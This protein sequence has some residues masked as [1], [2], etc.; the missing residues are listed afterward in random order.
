[1]KQLLLKASLPVALMLAAG[2][3]GALAGTYTVDPASPIGQRLMQVKSVREYRG[4]LPWNMPGVELNNRLKA[5]SPRRV[6]GEKPLPA[7][8]FENLPS[9][10]FI[11]G[12]DGSVWFYTSEYTYLEGTTDNIQT[13]TF[14]VYNS[15][16]ELQGSIHDEVVL[17]EGETRAVMAELDPS[18]TTK[19]FNSDSK[20]EVMVTFAINTVD[21]TVKYFNKAYSL[22][23]QKADGKDVPLM[24]IP[25][26][27]VDAINAAADKWSEDFYLTFV[28]DVQPDE[29]EIDNYES[30]VDYLNAFYERITIY[31]KGGYNQGPSVLET[32]Q[33]PLTHVPYDTMN[34]VYFMSKL[35]QGRP[36]FVVSQYEK[37]FLVDPTGFADDLSATADNNLV[38][39]IYTMKTNYDKQITKVSTTSIPS[40]QISSP[41]GLAYTYYGIGSLAWDKDID[42]TVNGSAEAPAFIVT[43]GFSLASDPDNIA[44]SYIVYDNA[45]NVKSLIAE[46]TDGVLL[47]S[48]IAGQ[49]PQAMFVNIEGNQY[50]FSFIDLYSG[51]LQMSLDQAVDGQPL[52]AIGDRVA[53]ADGYKYAFMM[54]NGETDKDKNYYA[55]V[56]WINR[57]GT[58]DHIDRINVGQ[59]TLRVSVNMAKDVLNPYL[60]DT[61]AEMEY[62]VLTGRQLTGETR[63]N[64]EFH[65]VKANQNA[66]EPLISFTSEDGL[67][68]VLSF[69]FVPGSDCDRIHMAYNNNYSY[70]VAVYELPLR[71][72]AGGDGTEANP[73]LIASI[74]DL[75]QIKR[76]ASA[77]YKLSQDIDG[78]GFA[79][80]P[81]KD[82][83]GVLKGD[84]KTISNFTL[85][86][87]AYTAGIFDTATGTSEISGI[88][89]VD[90]V[91]RLNSDNSK[92]ALL[93]GS[94]MGATIKDIHVYGLKASGSEFSGNFGG[95]VGQASLKTTIADCSVLG[96]D[97]N[98]PQ[99]DAIGGIVA[100]TR[101]GITLS[102]SAFSGKISGASNIGGIAGETVSGD[103]V[104]TD[105]HV[106]ADITGDNNIGGIIGSSARSTVSHCYVEGNL[107]A[108]TPGRWNKAYAVGG[109]V[110][111]LAANYKTVDD[112][113]N[114]IPQTPIVLKNIVALSSITWPAG[115]ITE[116]YP[117]QTATMHRIVGFST[118]NAA[119]EVVDYDSDW[120]PIYGDPM[121]AENC[122]AD[123]Y[124]LASLPAADATLVGANTTEGASIDAIDRDFL[125]DV[126][127]FTFGKETASPWHEYSNSD[128]WLYHETTYIVNPVAVKVAE[129]EVFT[130]NLRFLA[131]TALTLDDVLGDF[132][133]EFDESGLEMTGNA[134]MTDNV[135]SVEFKALKE[136]VYPV[137]FYI[138][139]QKATASVEVIKGEESGIEDITAPAGEGNAIT[140]DGTTVSAPGHTI[141]VYTATG[142]QAAVGTD[143]VAID[144]LAKG[145]Y[146]AVAVDNAGRRS[147][148]KIAR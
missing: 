144:R 131:N 83:A 115:E 63:V 30:I 49:E 38:I 51:E 102:A 91:I 56:A 50:M 2:G 118:V 108:K 106:D 48:D 140:F 138:A 45:G 97:I 99:A 57:D 111:N 146:I 52:D 93:A 74:G 36:Y 129:N 116:D 47:M 113:G 60:Y 126:L 21:Y 68:A 15:S 87:N 46:D 69:S 141:T 100:D 67:G 16:F 20:P 75:Q 94:S 77:H 96:A 124:A 32:L 125:T 127:G 104:F 133:V 41:E 137:E 58:L 90:P 128:P 109:I 59:N 55:R 95:L 23:G 143:A 22:G 17:G 65:V 10:N 110:G 3:H 1:M 33:V 18:V 28:E 31:K 107:A 112:E 54:Q 92:A 24:T 114:P 62:A 14:N 120:N 8:T 119:P 61:D 53:T 42:M 117:G 123:N 147:S 19:F 26:I 25:G 139:S 5:K 73:Y 6:K 70:N 4:E 84:G 78:S 34:G 85:D 76:D 82:F 40:T 101:T 43:R 37:P 9:Y 35:H 81:I 12:P 27:C 39:D 122:L 132:M 145:V 130:L 79:F 7:V 71:A 66:W 136:G 80:T 29:S 89:F 148:L 135:L 142:V 72:M 105:L 88:T 11:E 64:Q 98:L 134:D 86:T 44:N 103:E 13:Y 121:G